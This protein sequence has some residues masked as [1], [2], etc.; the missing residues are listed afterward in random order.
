[1]SGA[2]EDQNHPV[3]DRRGAVR[4]YR[5]GKRVVRELARFR[6]HGTIGIVAVDWKPS[7]DWRAA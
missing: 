3:L 5:A 4:A 7:D 6:L 1:M 2:D